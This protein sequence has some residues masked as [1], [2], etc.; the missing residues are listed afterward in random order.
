MAKLWNIGQFTEVVEFLQPVR[1]VSASGERETTYR[2]QAERYCEVEDTALSAS[3]S[4]DALPEVQTL[5]LK[6]WSVAGASTEWRVRYG[7]VVYTI[8]KVARQ[9]GSITFYSVRRIDLCNE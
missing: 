7:G 2:K 4:H 9:R 3:S 6:T 8:D 1:V 5:L